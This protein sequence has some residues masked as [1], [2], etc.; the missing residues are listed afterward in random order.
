MESSDS[1]EAEAGPGAG[2]GP[3]SDS[4]TSDGAEEGEEGEGD[5]EEGGEMVVV[6]PEEVELEAEEETGVFWTRVRYSLCLPL[7]WCLLGPLQAPHTPAWVA[8]C[9]LCAACGY[10]PWSS[11]PGPG[12]ARSQ[13]FSQKSRGCWRACKSF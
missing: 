13:A 9:L 7:I 4:S 8:H 6:P 5:G 3:G 11:Q 10:E 12:P 2:A 1:P